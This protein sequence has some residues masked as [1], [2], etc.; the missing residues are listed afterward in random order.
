MVAAAT[1]AAT[2]LPAHQ[3]ASSVATVREG[4]ATFVFPLFCSNI[5]QISMNAVLGLLDIAG[6]AYVLKGFT[7]ASNEAKVI[8][9]GLGK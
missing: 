4:C 7:G 6:I 1:L 3:E 8:I 5:V 9:A 2:V